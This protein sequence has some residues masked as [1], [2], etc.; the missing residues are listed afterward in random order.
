METDDVLL[1]KDTVIICL[2]GLTEK[3]ERKDEI[4]K[5]LCYAQCMNIFLLYG[6]KHED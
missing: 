5:D 1:E 2:M 4:K 6:N 3:N